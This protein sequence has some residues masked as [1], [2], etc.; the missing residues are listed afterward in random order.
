MPV[1]VL[2]N[3]SRVAGSVERYFRTYQIQVGQ[4]GTTQIL[5]HD[6]RRINVSIRNS[7]IGNAVFLGD[8]ESTAATGF[9]L[10]GGAAEVFNTQTTRRMWAVTAPTFTNPPTPPTE[11]VSIL[12]IMAEYEK[13][14]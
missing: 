7:T 3:L 2:D 13:E 4:V 11:P 12:C 5:D 10:L 8:T 9:E 6:P 14:I 1:V